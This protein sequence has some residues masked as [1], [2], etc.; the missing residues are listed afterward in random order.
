MEYHELMPLDLVHLGAAVRA[1]TGLVTT[2]TLE[3]LRVAAVDM[4]AMMVTASKL[5][6][7]RSASQGGTATGAT[8]TT[9]SSPSSDELASSPMD[10]SCPPPSRGVKLQKTRAGRVRKRA[11]RSSLLYGSEK[12]TSPPAPVS[13]EDDDD[14]YENQF[15]SDPDE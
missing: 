7:G 1:Q 8:E 6:G 2:P 10:T 4:M 9:S 11:K 5:D 15:I 3:C 12:R 13:T 14:D